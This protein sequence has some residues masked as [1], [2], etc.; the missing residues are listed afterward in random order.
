VTSGELGRPWVALGGLGGLNK[1]RGG[2]GCG[3]STAWEFSR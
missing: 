2:L 3:L 1:A